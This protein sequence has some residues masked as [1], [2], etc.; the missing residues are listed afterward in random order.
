MH[1]RH[2]ISATILLVALSV[3]V[4][5][6]AG[7]YC[8]VLDGTQEVPPKLTPATG[9]GHMTL[10]ATNDTLY[11]S[12][13]YSGLLAARTAAHFHA[14]APPGVNAG[15]VQGIA[16]AGPTSDTIVGIWLIPAAQLANLLAGQ[17]YVNVH[18]S[19]YP[20]GEIRGQLVPC[21]TPSRPRTWGEIRRMFR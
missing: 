1:L 2:I 18:T 9:F 16:G 17:M 13:Q 3:S 14:P 8:A 12:V 11:Y 21:S 10:S 19:V 15:V 4:A 5:M 7:D 6:A 20:G